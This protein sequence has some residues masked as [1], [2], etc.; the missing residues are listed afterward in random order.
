MRHLNL[1]V[2]FVPGA[3]VVTGL[4]IAAPPVPA[5]LTKSVLAVEPCKI[6]KNCPSIGLGGNLTVKPAPPTLLVFFKI[7]I[8]VVAVVVTDPDTVGVVNSTA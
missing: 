4:T 7:K 3:N 2:K 5:V 6:V 8:E 1:A